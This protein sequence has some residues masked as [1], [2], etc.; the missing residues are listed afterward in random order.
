MISSVSRRW[1][2][3]RA[4]SAVVSFG[5]PIATNVAIAN[6]PCLLAGRVA[7]GIVTAGPTPR[8]YWYRRACQGLLVAPSPSWDDHPPPC[9]DTTAFA[10][11]ASPWDAHGR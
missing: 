6:L 1:T 3:C 2:V 10:A 9:A 7:A 4:S 5:Y 11:S 8:G